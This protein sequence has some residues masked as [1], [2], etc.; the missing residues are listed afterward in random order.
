MNFVYECDAPMMP[1]Y[2]SDTDGSVVYTVRVRPSYSCRLCR[3]RYCT[4]KNGA[5]VNVELRSGFNSSTEL[6]VSGMNTSGS[7]SVPADTTTAFAGNTAAECSSAE[8]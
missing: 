2:T 6:T 1:E 8:S 4:L 5:H 7:P 3:L